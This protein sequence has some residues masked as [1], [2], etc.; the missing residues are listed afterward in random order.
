MA[1]RNVS[2]KILAWGVL[3]VLGATAGSAP[4]IAATPGPFTPHG[5]NPLGME[6]LIDYLAQVPNADLACYLH[7]QDGQQ[8]DLSALCGGFEAAASEVILQT[9]DVQVTLR[10]DTADDL[11][12]FVRDPFNEEV[13]YFNPEVPSGGQLDVDAN[14]GCAERMGSPV[15]NIFWPT[16]GGAPGDY[17]VTVD[18]F[19]Y[20]G[21]EVPINFTL[22]TLIQDQTQTQTGTVS[23]SQTSVSFPFTFPS[24]ETAAGEA[25]ALTGETLPAPNA[26]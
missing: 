14:A 22:T 16:G 1:I 15:E 25:E 8:Y 18:L 3:G 21:A 9:G 24:G 10:W 11:D 4:A 20:C 23:S 17:V 6:P 12:L 7:S 5:M 19:S 26:W 2:L 13:S